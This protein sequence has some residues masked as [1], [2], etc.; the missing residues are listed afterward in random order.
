MDSTGSVTH[1]ISAL[2]AGDAAA[3][4]LWERYFRRL[5]GLASKRLRMARR[6]AEDEEDVALSALD[7]FCR[8]ARQG[9]FPQ[10]AHRNNLCWLLVVVTV[11]KAMACRAHGRVPSADDPQAPRKKPGI[12]RRAVMG[13]AGSC[14]YPW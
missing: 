11:R 14:G 4:Q 10:L 6:R 1:W 5:V 3:E 8:G 13:S 12:P 2:K 7:S 9:R